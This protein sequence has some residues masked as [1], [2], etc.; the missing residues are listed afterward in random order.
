MGGD[1]YTARDFLEL[2]ERLDEDMRDKT[3]EVEELITAA[4]ALG[5]S[6]EPEHKAAVERSRVVREEWTQLLTLI[7]QRIH[8]ALK[9]T[10]FHKKAQQVLLLKLK[11]SMNSCAISGI[12][13]SRQLLLNMETE[14]KTLNKVLIQLVDTFVISEEKCTIKP[15]F[16]IF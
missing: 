14:L 5:S 7:E 13:F 2:H 6:G 9:Y 1:L 16:N 4:Q 15:W 8:L 10:T 3:A 11:K 12:L